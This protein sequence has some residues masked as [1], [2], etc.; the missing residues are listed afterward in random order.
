MES[1][2]EITKSHGIHCTI[3]HRKPRTIVRGLNTQYRILM[4]ADKRQTQTTQGF[5][6]FPATEKAIGEI[7]LG[8]LRF[9]VSSSH[10]EAI[11][12]FLA[13]HFS[14]EV[15]PRHKGWSGYL[16]SWE[17][18]YSILMGM[19]PIL[20]QAQR[21][22]MGIKKSPNEGYLT[23][24]IP[25]SAVETLSAE[26]TWKLWLDLAAF[27]D[28]KLSRIDIYY[29]DFTKSLKPVQLE[30]QIR[31]REIAVPKVQSMRF[32][33]KFD[34]AKQKRDGGTVYLGS[35]QSDKQVRIYDKEAESGGEKKCHRLEMQLVNDKAKAFWQLIL[36]ALERG[37]D[38]SSSDESGSHII[39]TY[40]QVLVGE[41]DF[42]EVPQNHANIPLPRNWAT[43]F[44]RPIW[45]ANIVNGI[46]GA[47]LVVRRIKPTLASEVSWIR[48]QVMPAL[49]LVKTA[50][51]NWGIP[52]Q[53]WLSRELEKGEERWQDRHWKILE[54]VM[55]H[56]PQ[57]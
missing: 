53:A 22:E 55:V 54:E 37:L 29:D 13:T 52:W 28:L 48:K 30:E 10:Y 9:T 47:K 43:R 11:V 8:W 38:C 24:D 34:L 33:S 5:Q 3:L 21:E 26:Q 46:A 20:T 17:A 27:D 6:K 35:S 49:A 2:S 57:T 39:D 14:T 31:L 15:K 36:E 1:H 45:W 40:R 23:V 32:F 25:Q 56:S 50:Y 42:R 19:T 44:N 7:A 51:K 12:N 4:K 18:A 16:F 41:I